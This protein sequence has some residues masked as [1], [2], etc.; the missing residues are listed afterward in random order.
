MRRGDRT[1]TEASENSMAVLVILM[2]LAFVVAL[3][4]A[5]FLF[6][7]PGLIVG[8]LL[9]VAIAFVAIV[10]LTADGLMPQKKN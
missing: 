5:V 7:Y 4:G 3:V 1:T 10:T 8:A 6:G 2:Q 9:G